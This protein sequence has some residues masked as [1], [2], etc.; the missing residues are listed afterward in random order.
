M[1][2]IPTTVVALAPLRMSANALESALRLGEPT[3]VARIHD[4]RLLL[5]PRTLSPEDEDAVVARLE[6]IASSKAG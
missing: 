1:A 4:D 6:Q 5:D 3:I 2:E